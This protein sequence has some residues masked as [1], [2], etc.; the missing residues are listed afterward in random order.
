MAQVDRNERQ[1]DQELP[2]GRAG[3]AS[4][5]LLSDTVKGNVSS[6]KVRTLEYQGFDLEN[7]DIAKLTFQAR[8]SN[9]TQ[10]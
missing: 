4:S 6:E 9:A 7:N 3:A 2:P 8:G 10:I 5:R 1:K